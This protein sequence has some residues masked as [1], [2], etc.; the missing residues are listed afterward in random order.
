LLVWP[1]GPVD[2]AEVPEQL[3]IVPTRIGSPLGAALADDEAAAADV[4]AEL[5]AFPLEQAETVRA[6]ITANT[7]GI[8]A[9]DTRLFIVMSH[10][11]GSIVKGTCPPCA[12]V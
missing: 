6:T 4:V 5:V 12:L 3:Q 9:S 2:A 7:T 10:P 8:A 1:A 11:L